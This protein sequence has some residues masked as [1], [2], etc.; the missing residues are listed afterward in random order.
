MRNTKHRV[1]L[2]NRKLGRILTTR[3]TDAQL[4]SLIQIP[5]G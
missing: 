3:N 2:R 1:N 4:S 5:I